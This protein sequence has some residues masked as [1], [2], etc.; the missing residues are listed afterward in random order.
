MNLMLNEMEAAPPKKGLVTLKSRYEPDAHEVRISVADN[1]PGID[2][3]R[4]AHVFDAFTSTKGQR[5]TGLGLAVTRKIVEEHGG[6][7]S[8]ESAPGKGTTVTIALGV[9]RPDLDAAET[10]LPRPIHEDDL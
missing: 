7:V 1:G 8:I 10:H 2:P 6:E 9:D 4:L 5:G 3:A